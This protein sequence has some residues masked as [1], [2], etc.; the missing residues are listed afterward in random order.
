[1]TN[2]APR[3]LCGDLV[4][5][6]PAERRDVP[7][8][9]AFLDEPEVGR[10]WPPPPADEDVPFDEPGLV[11][12]AIESAGEVAGLIQFLEEL[13][14]D[15]RHASIDVFLGTAFHGRGL[16][17]DAVRTVVRHLILDRGHHRLTID[18]TVSNTRAIAAYR[19]V[20]FR[21]V[22]VLREQERDHATGGWRDGLLMDLLARDVGLTPG[23]VPSR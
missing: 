13:E 16:G 7:T 21:E 3:E 1:M 20:G 19:R 8:L 11:V 5:L 23:P 6:R 22:G 12:L 2:D 14:P 18:P 9:R 4:R 10:W 17:P 15:D